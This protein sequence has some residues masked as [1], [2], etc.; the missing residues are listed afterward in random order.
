M[1]LVGI[2]AGRIHYAP[3]CVGSF[4]G[5]Q[6]ISV[7]HGTDPL[8]LRIKEKF[9]AVFRGIFS[10]SDVQPKGAY[11][12]ARRG[13][14]SRYRLVGYI[15]L[16]L[17]QFIPVYNSK[18]LNTVFHAVFI[19]IFQAVHLGF[20]RA[21]N[22][23]TIAGERKVQFLGQ[24]LHHPISLYVQLCHQRAVG[25]VISGMDDGAVGL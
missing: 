9:S 11:N 24:R 17:L 2:N 23:G 12:A 8:H 10:Q 16:H 4:T 21:D 1:D 5:G 20:V 6:F 13:V 3:A 7:F 22:Q 18:T 14:Q 15:G 25:S 19:Q